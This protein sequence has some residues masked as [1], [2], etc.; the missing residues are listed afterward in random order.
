MK[1]HGGRA[2]GRDEFLRVRSGEERMG[3]ASTLQRAGRASEGQ[4]KPKDRFANTSVSLCSRNPDSSLTG[5]EE[6]LGCIAM[7][8]WRNRPWRNAV[9]SKQE[10]L[11][12][13]DAL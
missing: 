8:Y 4:W 11:V 3:L 12:L 5:G 13:P 2:V 1:S 7:E 6:S 10:G 9:F